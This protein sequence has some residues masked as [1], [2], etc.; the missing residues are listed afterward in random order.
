MIKD[1]LG[2]SMTAAGGSFFASFLIGY[3]IRKIIRILMSTFGAVLALLIYFQSQGSISVEVNA[4]KI[5]SSV[6]DIL[7]TI[8]ANA[9]SNAFPTKRS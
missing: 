8:V 5:Q 2:A 4:D 6:E 1:Y 9:T 3:F 7:N